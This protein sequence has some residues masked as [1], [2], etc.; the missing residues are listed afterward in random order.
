MDDAVVI[1]YQNDIGEVT[2]RLSDNFIGLINVTEITTVENSC[3]NI[4]WR[5]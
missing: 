5:K 2:R 4:N 1:G 3:N